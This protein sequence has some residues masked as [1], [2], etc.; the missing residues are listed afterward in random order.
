MYDFVDNLD[1]TTQ[2]GYL[3]FLAVMYDVCLRC[4]IE[5][6]QEG[7]QI[8]DYHHYVVHVAEEFQYVLV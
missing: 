6:A 3:V 8:I 4:K 5:C 7:H 2:T 1:F